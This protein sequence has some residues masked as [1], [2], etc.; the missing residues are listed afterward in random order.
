M[1]KNITA[2]AAGFA[3]LIALVPVALAADKKPVNGWRFWHV[4]RG[5]G[6]WV[7]LSEKRKA[8]TPMI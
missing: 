3:T 1:N 7:R 2:I 4:E 6:N 8:G 5:R